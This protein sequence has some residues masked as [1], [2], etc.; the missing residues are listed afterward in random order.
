MKRFSNIDW[1][2]ILMVLA[3]VGWIMLMAIVYMGYLPYK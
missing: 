2:G 1:Y 3:L